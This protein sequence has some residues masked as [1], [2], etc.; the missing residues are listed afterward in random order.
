[1]KKWLIFLLFAALLC[2]PLTAWAEPRYPSK[3]APVTDAAAV[4]SASTVQD[5]RALAEEF[6]DEDTLNLYVV[7]VDFLD[8]ATLTNYGQGLR[9]KWDLE[10]DDLLLLMAVGEDKFGFFGGADVNKRLS[11]AA[12]Q[13]L[14]ST[15]F[16]SRFLRQEYDAA[17]AA[18]MP[19]LAQEVSKAWNEEI[20][21]AGLFGT[22]SKSP[23]LTE[24]DWLIRPIE[25]TQ[26]TEREVVR[27]T[28]YDDSEFN[29]GTVVMGVALLLIIFANNRRYP[30]SNRNRNRNRNGGRN[31]C[32]CGCMPFAPLLAGL[33]LWQLFKRR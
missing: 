26:Q 3:Q 23:L 33:G 19:P 11:S 18:L 14:L 30:G 27:Y 22:A 1:M 21:V 28:T 7:T 9:E 32:G 8:G 29:I 31:G 6:E 2:L 4:L 20:D 5:L 17:I 13:K 12:Q 25:Q 16:E 24:R 10:S 15:H